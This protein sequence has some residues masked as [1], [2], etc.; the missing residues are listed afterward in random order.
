MIDGTFFRG[1]T[2]T[3]TFSI[4]IARDLVKD[5]RI[6]YTQD[7]KKILTKQLKDVEFSES[8]IS[9]TLTQEETL[10]FQGG[11]VTQIQLKL[12]TIDDSVLGSDIMRMRVDE[13][14]DDEVI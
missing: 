14:L 12:K 2:P 8:D 3:H 9:V 5:L 6:T 11:K 1:T 7:K 10:L 13:I 4:P